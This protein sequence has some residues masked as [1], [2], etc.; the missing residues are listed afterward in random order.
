MADQSLSTRNA[1][2][3]VRSLPEPS[4]IEATPEAASAKADVDANYAAGPLTIDGDRFAVNYHYTSLCYLHYVSDASEN[5][6]WAAFS[7][8][9]AG[10]VTNQISVAPAH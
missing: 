3:T 10:H 9:A 1:I 7:R 4:R 5:V 6:Y 2:V 8:D